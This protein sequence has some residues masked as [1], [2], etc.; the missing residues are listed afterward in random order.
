MAHTTYIVRWYLLLSHD[1][2][3]QFSSFLSIIKIFISLFMGNDSEFEQNYMLAV[4]MQLNRLKWWVDTRKFTII[5]KVIDK[6][7]KQMFEL[8][9]KIPIWLP[10]EAD[11]TKWLWLFFN[12][13]GQMVIGCSLLL[14][15]YPWIANSN[16]GLKI[17]NKMAFDSQNLHSTDLFNENGFIDGVSIS[18]EFQLLFSSFF[19][20]TES[21]NIANLAFY[22]KIV[23]KSMICMLYK[24]ITVRQ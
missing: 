18:C 9:F 16:Y 22:R 1:I 7:M 10:F 24:K 3:F 11:P 12:I 21:I 13:D 8:K 19:W 15:A 14:N 2:L 6:L 17:V 20:M 23:N 4:K 5:A